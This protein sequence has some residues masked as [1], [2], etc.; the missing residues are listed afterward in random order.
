M[1]SIKPTAWSDGVVGTLAVR[2]VLLAVSIMRRSVN[3]PPTSIPSVSCDILY[4]V[5]QL[6]LYATNFLGN[7]IKFVENA[8]LVGIKPP[9]KSPRS[10]FISK[11]RG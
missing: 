7:V 4:P 3:V 5:T 2:N 6:V 9:K 8:C 1:A 11:T 10:T